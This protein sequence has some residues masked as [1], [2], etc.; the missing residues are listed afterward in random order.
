MIKS[1][2]EAL[3][4]LRSIVMR[5]GDKWTDTGIPRVAMVQAEACASQ[6]YQPMLHLVLQGSKTLSIGDQVTE[7]AAVSYFI[8]SVDV[9]AAGDIHAA[10]LG[11]PYLAVNL[12]LDPDVIASVLTQGNK[13]LGEPTATSFASVNAPTE[14]IDAWLRMMRLVDHPEEAAVMAP[15]I[16]REILFRALQGPLGGMLRELACP[17]GRLSQIRRVIHWIREHFAEPLRVEPLAAMAEMSVAAFYRHFKSVTAMTPIQYQKRLRLLRARWVLLF[18]S[19]DAAAVAFS[20][21]YESASQF[22][23]EYARMFGLPPTRDI[24]RFRSGSDVSG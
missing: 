7:Y 20:V 18:D 13:G 3:D 2:T 1:M 16:E 5:A 23:R 12:T 24:A 9:P 6:V 4:E 11:R 14:M 22:S 10:G 8:V 15:M 17:D 21:G 19:R